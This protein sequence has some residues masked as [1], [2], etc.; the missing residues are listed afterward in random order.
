VANNNSVASILFEG[1]ERILWWYGITMV[2]YMVEL[3]VS[4]RALA[5]VYECVLRRTYLRI[6]CF[7]VYLYLI[8]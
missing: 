1:T 5:I 7:S 3:A 6:I 2:L 4:M 8:E